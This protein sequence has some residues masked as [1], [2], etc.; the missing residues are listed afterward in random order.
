MRE[1]LTQQAALAAAYLARAWPETVEQA[2]AAL[3]PWRADVRRILICG[4]GDSH[5]AARGAEYGVGLWSGL[6]V[7]AAEA[8]QAG[9]Y[10]LDDAGPELL[11]VGIS[12][13]GEVARTVEAVE[14]ARRCR[15][16]TLAITASPESTLAGAADAEVR[17]TL[18]EFPFGPGLVSYLGAIQACLAVAWS[19]APERSAARLAGCL[20]ELPERVESD[21][22]A[23]T[24]AAEAFA[25]EVGAEASGVVL[26]S[27]PCRGAAE[28]A[29]AKVMEA[30]GLYYRAQDVEEWAHLEYFIESPPMP[31]W[32]LSADGRS[33]S[34]EMEVEQAALAVGRRLLVTRWAG[35][36]GWSREEREAL[37]PLA[38]WA[39]PA[40]FAQR[41]MMRRQAVPFRDFGGGRSAA[42]GG[43]ASRIRSSE[44]GGWHS[45]G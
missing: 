5:C 40:A 1:S 10:L 30:C 20:R 12:S 43:G 36:E 25:D 45:K 23:Q 41:L 2:R 33:R 8:M 38:L 15:A 21:R 27:G 44:R 37:A 24:A 17:L 29:A 3:G 26:G 42:E 13:S 16:R 32:L 4:C 39:G 14:T 34:R 19:F 35:A 22:P 7:R 28:F 11:V 9:R 6:P 18:P 31:T